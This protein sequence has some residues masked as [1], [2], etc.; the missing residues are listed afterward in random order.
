[1]KTKKHIAGVILA[2]L[3]FSAVASASTETPPT[4]VVKAVVAVNGAPTVATSPSKMTVAN[5]GLSKITRIGTALQFQFVDSNGNAVNVANFKAARADSSLVRNGSPFGTWTNTP[6]G[7]YHPSSQG[8]PD[9]YCFDASGADVSPSAG[10]VAGWNGDGSG[11]TIPSMSKFLLIDQTITLGATAPNPVW[12][13]LAVAG[14]YYSLTYNWV[15]S[16]TYNGVPYNNITLTPSQTE[17]MVKVVEGIPEFIGGEIPPPCTVELQVSDY[18]NH[19]VTPPGVVIPQPRPTN[20][21]NIIALAP[22]TTDVAG[23]PTVP[24]LIKNPK[25]FYRYVQTPLPL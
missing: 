10:F 13:K 25:R 2:S 14:D 24:G 21:L 1:M 17:V 19:W 11:T 15:F 3:V 23:L 18:M 8:S 5:V 7:A 12:P 4:I 16:Y 9:Y 20:V 22:A 6:L